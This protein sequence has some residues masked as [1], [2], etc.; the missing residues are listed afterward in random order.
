MRS[1]RSQGTPYVTRKD[2]AGRFRTFASTVHIDGNDES[3][4]N[5]SGGNKA[6]DIKMRGNQFHRYRFAGGPDSPKSGD[7][8]VEMTGNLPGPSTTAQVKAEGPDDD[9]WFGEDLFFVQVKH[10]STWNGDWYS[11]R[12]D[13]SWCATYKE[14]EP[15][16]SIVHVNFEG[17]L[18]EWFLD[19]IEDHPNDPNAG[20]EF[21]EIADTGEY[22]C[23]F[24][25][26]GMCA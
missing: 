7:K 26:A 25:V 21:D 3:S 22:P 16:G 18:H 15:D 11:L 24:T 5:D 14:A 9:G 20:L 4:C 1:S 10:T 19:T 2:G 12:G 17:L 13:C 8:F 23:A 6:Y